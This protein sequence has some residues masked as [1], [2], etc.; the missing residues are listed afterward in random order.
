[1]LWSEGNNVLRNEFNWSD[2]EH[3]SLTAAALSSVF[4]AK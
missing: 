1:M 3:Q 2:T 4:L